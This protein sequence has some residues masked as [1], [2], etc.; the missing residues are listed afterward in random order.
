MSAQFRVV[1]RQR[2]LAVVCALLLWARAVS[3]QPAATTAAPASSPAEAANATQIRS[4]IVRAS[5]KKF[6]P[7]SGLGEALVDRDPR[8]RENLVAGL[9]SGI[10]L[11]ALPG[12]YR[13]YVWGGTTT[14]AYHYVVAVVGTR[15]ICSGV[16][17]EGNVVLTA[18][19]CFC[20]N[21]IREV[22]TGAAVF[23]GTSISVV[24]VPR[25]MSTDA[26]DGG[27]GGTDV[28][29]LYLPLATSLPSVRLATQ[30]DLASLSSR[31]P[32]VLRLVGYGLTKD[33]G[34]GAKNYV[35]LPVASPDCAGSVSLSAGRVPDADYYGCLVN[36]E[37]VAGAVGLDADACGGD[38]G[39]P[40][41]LED[42]GAAAVVAISS[43]S[44][45]RRRSCGDGAVYSLCDTTVVSF[46]QSATAQRP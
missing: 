11:G 6:V 25:T 38:S 39:A 8:Y 37:L 13:P 3:G 30:S 20:N 21:T 16:V 7:A 9:K 32:N 28:G 22:H 27:R 2:Q 44:V 12:A 17:L 45:S 10:D 43:R 34:L 40:L 29:L 24:G 42:G 36:R 19:H 35:D 33:G 5:G 15:E 14:S 18:A 23:R 4:S 26:C 46:L 1:H 41:I 31:R